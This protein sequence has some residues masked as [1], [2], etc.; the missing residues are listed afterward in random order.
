MIIKRLKIFNYRDV[1]VR[2]LEFPETGVVIVQG[3]NDVGKSSLVEAINLVIDEKSSS[4]KQSV[5]S[6]QPYGSDVGSTVEL[7]IK[8]GD[9]HF[10]ITKT[11]NRTNR[12]E[13]EIHA[14]STQKLTGDEAHNRMTEIL[15]ETLDMGLWKA[16]RIDQGHGMSQVGFS[17]ASWL[18]SSL[19]G[20]AGQANSGDVD[21]PIFLAAEREYGNY[22]T[23]TG[24][25]TGVLKQ[26]ET[27]AKVLGTQ[28]EN[29]ESDVANLKSDIFASESL[30][31]EFVQRSAA[32]ELLKEKSGA[33]NAA[34]ELV[35]KK[36][37]ELIRIEG[38]AETANAS[39]TISQ[40]ASDER[41]KL[42]KS[43]DQAKKNRTK[44]QKE[45]SVGN[46]EGGLTR[47]RSSL[48]IKVEKASELREET[49]SAR[50]T[51]TSDLDHLRNVSELGRMKAR[52]GRIIKA[53]KTAEPAVDWIESHS[54]DENNVDDIDKAFLQFEVARVAVD[55]ASVTIE[56]TP[57]VDLELSVD[58]TS[59]SLEAGEPT[60]H[61][62]VKK[63]T[64]DIPDQLTIEII[65]AK[66]AD[67]LA[68]QLA[69]AEE[70]YAS[71]CQAIGV[72][73]LEESRDLLALKQ[74]HES[75]IA[76]RDRVVNDAL[77]DNDLT[78]AELEGHIETYS[79]R[80]LNYKNIRSSNLDLP[81]GQEAARSLVE[82]FEASLDPLVE[83]ERDLKD[84][85]TEIDAD[86]GSL[87][88]SQ[89]AASAKELAAGLDVER[90]E[91][92]LSEVR[93]SISDKKLQDDLEEK[94]AEHTK[95]AKQIDEINQDLESLNPKRAD[96]LAKNAG[97][98]LDDA[99]E[100]LQEIRDHKGILSGR[101]ETYS[102]R[103]IA[104]SFELAH[105][106]FEQKTDERS[107]IERR[108][109][110]AELLYDI[111]NEKR[112]ET[113]QAYIGPLKKA[114][115]EKGSIVFDTSFEVELNE[116]FSVV[117][118][119]LGGKTIEV[120]RIGGGAQEQIAIISRLAV[121]ELVATEGGVPMIFD[122][123]LGYSDPTKLER[124]SAVMSAAGD[125][126]Q[127]I[128]LTC[129]PERY[130]QIGSAEVIRLP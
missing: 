88:E 66:T 126:S 23:G 92:S 107:R 45:S 9:Y 84:E 20:A 1:E 130:Q 38:E 56:M 76:L 123:V 117:E 61:A 113:L 122:D 34:L 41:K 81:E 46:R 15:E 4:K 100:Q 120:E 64:I 14:P 35:D 125:S 78:R 16:L 99:A 102:Q 10:T 59:L 98:S 18:R 25:S 13:L 124:I 27:D 114:I 62:L 2:E 31:H 96:L 6:V 116:D 110:A 51:Y 112:S 53:T 119:T 33:E 104:E 43:S 36:R 89:M 94:L 97:K 77:N 101:L 115:E 55:S 17:E 57:V 82:K 79:Q 73:S 69:D 58:G 28:V 5:K 7:E 67:V 87:L 8:T 93:S 24:R 65:P 75:A 12:T 3:P 85:I 90:L 111:L 50:D 40:H 44:L 37:I 121:G 128:V 83:N 52:Q 22:Y 68:Q 11:F 91:G 129:Q 49:E 74:K 109:K 106:K 127:I 103:G 30:E 108:A 21:E 63:S 54:L 48:A 118:R 95:F 26:A 47:R 29:L 71:K 86:L 70:S 42:I 60:S 105:S 32:L 72:D 39:L 80:V 19:D